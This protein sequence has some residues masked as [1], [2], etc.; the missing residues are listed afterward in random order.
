MNYKIQI[1]KKQFLKIVSNK[2]KLPTFQ[3]LVIEKN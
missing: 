2:I 3:K 1:V